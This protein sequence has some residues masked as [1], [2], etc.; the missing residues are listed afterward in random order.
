MPV[1]TTLKF[2][3][4]VDGTINSNISFTSNYNT[5]LYDAFMHTGPLPSALLSFSSTSIIDTDS[6]NCSLSLLDA[7]TLLP[8]LYSWT[9]TGGPSTLSLS[10]ANQ[11]L[12]EFDGST[13][14]R[15]NCSFLTSIAI[16]DS[17]FIHSEHYR[18]LC[19]EP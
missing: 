17:K 1:T 16:A 6:V 3:Y 2:Y 7:G 19:F 10:P 4:S 12:Y 8:D 13:L 18:K 5:P 14:L 11:T 15:W 9:Q